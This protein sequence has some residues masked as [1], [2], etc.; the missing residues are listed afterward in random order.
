MP[1]T[2]A[3]RSFWA[4]ARQPRMIGLLVLFLVAAAVCARLGVWQLDRAQQRADLAAQQEAAE[5]EAEGPEGLGVLLPPQTT[6]PGELVGRQAWVEGEYEPDEQLLVAGRALDGR[7]GFLVLTPLRVTDDGTGGASWQDLSGAPV[8]P[9]VRG[10]VP[11]P[12]AGAALEVPDGVVRLTGY[13]QASEAAGEAELPAGRTD[14]ISTGALVNDWGGPIYSGYLV[15]I[16]SDPAQVAA[17]DGGPGILPRPTIE[18]GTGLNLQNVFYA[19]QWWVFGGF[20]VLLWLRLVR[21]E[22]AGGRGAGAA[23]TTGSP[24]CPPRRRRGEV[25]PCP[26]G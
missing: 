12:D 9:V 18:G 5:A 22:V 20:A 24:A 21:D 14:S 15:L 23:T 4:V 7:E 8:L 26:D 3:P 13:L 1:E 11:T 17:A 2:A 10:W 6:F 19:L 16:A 25:P